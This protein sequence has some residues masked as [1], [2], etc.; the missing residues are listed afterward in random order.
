M[1][2]TTDQFL[3]TS[4]IAYVIKDG[5]LDHRIK[6]VTL[7]GYG[8]EILKN[9]TRV[10]DDLALAPGRCGAASGS[11]PVSVGQPTL[12]ISHRLVGGKKED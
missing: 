5:K 12:L 7:T 1:N 3:F 6:P 11:I 2:P 8:Y 9:I 10:G 4:D